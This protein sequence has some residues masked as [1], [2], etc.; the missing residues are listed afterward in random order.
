[1]QGSAGLFANTLYLLCQEMQGS[2][3]IPGKYRASFVKRLFYLWQE[4]IHCVNFQAADPDGWE[5][6]VWEV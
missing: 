1:M 2:L 4:L 5:A 6:F 3:Q